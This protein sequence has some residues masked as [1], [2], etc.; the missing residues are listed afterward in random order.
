M[1][2]RGLLFAAIA[3]VV[4]ATAVP[5]FATYMV[6]FGDVDDDW[7]NE[8]LLCRPQ[9]CSTEVSSGNV[10]GVWQAVL[11]TETYLG[12]CGSAGV[13]GLFGTTTKNAT[14]SLQSF[15]GLTADGKVG[16]NTWSRADNNLV[17]IGDDIHVSYEANRSTKDL[18]FHRID[19][20]YEIQWRDYP[21]TPRSWHDT[22]HPDITMDVC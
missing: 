1:R 15:W 3:V 14:K 6:G 9:D 21:E 19:G 7:W 20:V 4:V 16:T 11:W 2:R 17:D 5:A 8:H 22:D 13:D 12:E 10:V 18:W